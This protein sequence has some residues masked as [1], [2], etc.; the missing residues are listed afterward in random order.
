MRAETAKSLRE[1]IQ[2]SSVTA[3]SEPLT[4]LHSN[5]T[6]DMIGWTMDRVS[7]PQGAAILDIGSGGG[8]ALRIFKD[9]GYHPVGLNLLLE[10]VRVVLDRGLDCLQGDMHDIVEICQGR[11]YSLVWLR[12]A[13]EH[14]PA[15]G[16]LLD[17]IAQITED[18]GYLYVEVPG[19]EVDA[20]HETNPN[21]WSVM[22]RKMWAV[23]IERAG[24]KL[25]DSA[26][27]Q[28]SHG[29]IGDCYYCFL[30]QKPA[31]N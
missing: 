16:F 6:A 28:F 19:S 31:A 13:A 30:A 7:I 29:P 24:F 10:D 26:T 20:K 17:Q 15:P 4:E 3:Y 12:H 21:H 25:I 9:R 22:G 18:R 8:E 11:K 2:R 1:Y 14:S 5:L 23:L 27:M